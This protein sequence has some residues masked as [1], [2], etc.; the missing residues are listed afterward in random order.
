MAEASSSQAGAP[1][2]GESKQNGTTEKSKSNAPDGDT[3][4]KEIRANG[5]TKTSPA[6]KGDGAAAPTHTSPKKRRKVNH[7]K[8]DWSLVSE[9]STG[10]CRL[11]VFLSQLAFTVGDR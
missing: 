7:G 1:A 11:T 10:W 5:N 2:G 9:Q 6:G 4:S 8:E 3:S